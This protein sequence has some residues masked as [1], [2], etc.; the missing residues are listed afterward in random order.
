MENIGLMINASASS[1]LKIIFPNL[2]PACYNATILSESLTH[3][4]KHNIVV[5]TADLGMEVTHIIAKIAEIPLRNMFCPPVWG[6]VGVNHLVDIN[7]TIHRYNEFQPFKRYQKVKNSSLCIGSLTPHM[8]TIEY[9]MFFD[10]S[11]W[12]KVAEEKV[13]KDFILKLI[14]IGRL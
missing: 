3:I 7:N 11:L 9:C 13:N 5:A 1:K 10:D 6:F 4:S 2:G 8:R 12:I 14:S